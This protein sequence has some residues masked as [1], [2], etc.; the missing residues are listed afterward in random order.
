M[1]DA[2]TV[3]VSALITLG[4]LTAG[5]I[6]SNF[7]EEEKYY[8]QAEQ[9]IMTCPGGLSGGTGTR[10]YLNEEQNSWDYCRGGWELIT[11]DLQIKEEPIIKVQG[12]CPEKY[13]CDPEGC[14]RLK[15]E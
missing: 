10:C 13:S 8:C 3:G 2:K 9:S 14:T 6:G 4:L 1:V 11:N 5:M 7:F 12:E 15:C